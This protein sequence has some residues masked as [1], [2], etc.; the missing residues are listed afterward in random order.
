M[1]MLNPLTYSHP[2]WTTSLA[3]TSTHDKRALHL[4][5]NAHITPLDLYSHPHW[6]T[7]LARTSTHNKRALHLALN[8]HITPLDLLP[9]TLL[10]LTAPCT[11][12]PHRRLSQ[13]NNNK[14][15]CVEFLP[16]WPA[17]GLGLAVMLLQVIT[18]R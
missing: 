11:S 2:H 14:Q 18:L 15:A 9:P 12:S 5:L 10:E 1:C 13:V 7:S 8:A 3:R 17:P 6:T 16:N 4:A